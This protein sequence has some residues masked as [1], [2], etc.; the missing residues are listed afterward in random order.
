MVFAALCAHLRFGL[1]CVDSCA[2]RRSFACVRT[3]Q[4]PRSSMRFHPSIGKSKHDASRNPEAI[5]PL[6]SRITFDA[7][8]GE[9]VR[10][11]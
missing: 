7:F 1:P 10:S 11:A 3:L 2:E 4:N 8:L 6:T 5:R 9:S